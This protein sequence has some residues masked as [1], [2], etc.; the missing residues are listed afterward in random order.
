[1][2]VGDTAGG[3]LPYSDTWDG[4]QWVEHG[5][6]PLPDEGG[7][8]S[9]PEG[10]AVDASGDVW[11][12]DS[13]HY[14]LEE[15]S[16]GG[17][18]IRAVGWGVADGAAELQTCTSDCRPGIPGAG[19][20]QLG[21]QGPYKRPVGIAIAPESAGGA[22]WVADPGNQRVEK[23][24]PEAVDV[25][26]AGQIGPSG[27]DHVTLYDPL[28]VAVDQSG[29]VWVAEWTHSE[30]DE[31]SEDGAP[32]REAYSEGGASSVAIDTATGDVWVS[33]IDYQ[34]VQEFSPSEDRFIATVGWGVTDGNPELETCVS[35]CLRGV[36]GSGAGQLEYPAVSPSTGTAIC[37]WPTRP[38]IASMSITTKGPP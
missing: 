15:F 10:V 36:G 24:L 23:F 5:V 16:A 25:R 33:D 35:D 26:Y 22:I 34:R 9:A 7:G 18:F 30:L 37:G 27:A 28:G 21:E 31:F 8:L 17:A 12:V 4:S 11:V 1:M 32:V 13:G 19:D 14:R 29:N 3:G 38:M 2:A 6:A 20:G